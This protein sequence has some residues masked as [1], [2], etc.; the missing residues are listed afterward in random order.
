MSLIKKE[1]Q[2]VLK[3]IKSDLAI[4]VKDIAEEQ[5]GKAIEEEVAHLSE[6]YYREIKVS[7]KVELV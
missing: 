2:M 4:K 7:Y 3:E 1:Q 5:I 6:K